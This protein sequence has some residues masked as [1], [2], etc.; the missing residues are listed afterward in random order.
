MEISIP[1][2]IDDGVI[3]KLAALGNSG[4]NGGQPGDILVK[5]QVS[6]RIKF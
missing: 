2:G 5:V 1:A 3:I 6:A 4:T